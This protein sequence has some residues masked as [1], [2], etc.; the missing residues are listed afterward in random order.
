M[1]E[2]TASIY[3]DKLLKTQLTNTFIGNHDLVCS[4][5]QPAVHCFKLI[6]QNQLNKDLKPETIRQIECLLSEDGGLETTAEPHTS[7]DKEDI[8]DGFDAGDLE[9]L[10]SDDIEEE[11]GYV[12]FVFIKN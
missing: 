7:G 8:L 4:C 12:D 3:T 6:L 11:E 1:T 5:K 10:F 2:F 9:K